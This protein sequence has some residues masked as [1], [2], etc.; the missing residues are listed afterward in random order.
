MSKILIFLISLTG[1]ALGAC[2]IAIVWMRL[3]ISN[4]A[5]ICGRLEDEREMVMREV[6]ELRGQR[7]WA[8]RPSVLASMVDGRLS[9]P[10]QDRTTHVT[11]AKLNS[12]SNLHFSN[13]AEGISQVVSMTTYGRQNR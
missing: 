13:N 9:M 12:R 11:V 5:K 4:S 7:S 8:L 1:L 2:S 10:A 3:E 6:Q